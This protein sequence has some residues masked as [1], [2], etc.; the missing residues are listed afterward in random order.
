MAASS[1]WPCHAPT[2]C[3]LSLLALLT[4]QRRNLLCAGARWRLRRRACRKQALPLL[5]W[6]RLQRPLQGRWT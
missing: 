1:S 2:L 6:H 4:W 3:L 5:S